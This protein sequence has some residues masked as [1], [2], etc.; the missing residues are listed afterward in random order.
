MVGWMRVLAMTA[1]KSATIWDIA[2]GKAV[3]PKLTHAPGPWER[4]IVAAS[5]GAAKS[6]APLEVRGEQWA[7]AFSRDYVSL[8]LLY[9][10]LVFVIRQDRRL[11]G[12]CSCHVSTVKTA[13]RRSG[14]RKTLHDFRAAVHE[15]NC[16][17]H[18][19]NAF[20]RKIP[21]LI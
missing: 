16:S 4:G 11:G 2:S 5:A 3:T 20:L 9:S 6:I 18:F 10:L 13:P 1:D 17:Q 14:D 12:R 7:A 15:P 19:K 21:L 8:N